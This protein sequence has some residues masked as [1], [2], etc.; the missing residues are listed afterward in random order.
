[1][2]ANNAMKRLLIL[3]ASIAL[4]AQ[5]GIQKSG[6]EAPVAEKKEKAKGDNED[7]GKLLEEMLNGLLG[8]GG[9][10]KNDA[11]MNSHFRELLDGHQPGSLA[12]A[13]ATFVIRDAKRAGRPLGFAT[14]VNANGWLI[15]KASEV[16]GAGELQVEVRG[17]WLAAKVTQTWK[18]HD[19][20]LLKTEVAD[21]PVAQWSA[22]PP[23]DVG[24]FI[25]AAAPEGRDAIAIGVVSVAARNIRM[26]G[27]G[28]LGV[29]VES[30]DKGLKIGRV[31]GKS[32]AERAGVLPGDRIVELDGK[33]PESVFGFTK[34]ISNKKAGDSIRLKV[35]RGPALVE[36][37]IALGDLASLNGGRG[38]SKREARMSAMG[39]TV[40]ERKGDFP[41]VIQTDFPLDASQC[42]GPVTDL[43]G[44]VVGIVIARS[45]RI[46]TLVLPSEAIVAALKDV[47][48]SK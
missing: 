15:T 46:E 20:A 32:A 23:P 25:T 11:R 40:S 16:N 14:G 27:R 8:G 45:G 6:G 37:E 39:S 30:D 36:K 22:L 19:L 21:L 41:S 29:Q 28:F 1:M 34:S 10:R 3:I 42:G 5:A 48:F 7:A 35:Q 13:K 26:Q 47:D 33:A 9:D 38:Q 43:D 2:K 17:Q 12:A 4:V 24:S 31:E 18:E 44:N